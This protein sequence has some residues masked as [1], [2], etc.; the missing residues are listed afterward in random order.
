MIYHGIQL[1]SRVLHIVVQ[2]GLIPCRQ[3][4]HGGYFN[5]LLFKEITYYI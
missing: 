4:A 2:Q 1:Q 3:K 5:N